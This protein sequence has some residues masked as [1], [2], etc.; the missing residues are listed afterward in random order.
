MLTLILLI[1]AV[2]SYKINYIDAP[3]DYSIITPR[4]LSIQCDLPENTYIDALILNDTN[5]TMLFAYGQFI[6]IPEPNQC[7]L[8]AQHF[9]PFQI[10]NKTTFDGAR[11]ANMSAIIVINSSKPEHYNAATLLSHLIK[12][13]GR[14]Y[15]YY[16]MDINTQFKECISFEVYRRH[17]PTLIAVDAAGYYYHSYIRFNS[18]TQNFSLATGFLKAVA[19][20]EY[21]PQKRGWVHFYL[22]Y[23]SFTYIY[24]NFHIMFNYILGAFSFLLIFLICICEK[25]ITKFIKP[26]AGKKEE[27]KKKED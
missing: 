19:N 17:L 2:I 18:R 5:H 21:S 27:K 13:G 20:G 15:T 7:Q 10:W 23:M 11:L 6:D 14:N 24:N 12:F 26:P 1:A 8:I 16:L 3:N 9:P 22:K 4:K 25:Q